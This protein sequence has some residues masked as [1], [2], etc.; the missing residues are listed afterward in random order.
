MDEDRMLGFLDRV[1]VDSGAG[2][3]GLSTSIGARLG[4]YEA[5]SGAGPLTV[6]ELARRTGLTEV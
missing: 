2:F 4:L 3:A 5:L 1:V 6:A